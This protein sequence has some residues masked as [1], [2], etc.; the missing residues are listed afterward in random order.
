MHV[1]STRKL[2]LA[3]YTLLPLALCACVSGATLS[4]RVD[5]LALHT[6]R[7]HDAA[8]R[9]EAEREIALAEAHLEFLRYE[10]QRGKVVPARRHSEIALSSID[11]VRAM[12]DHRPECF[13]IV[14]ITDADADGV[15]DVDDNC[16]YTPNPQQIDI[17]DDGQGD[18]CDDDMDGDGV[19]NDA[20]NCPRTPNPDQRDSN[21][22][23]RG[24]LCS[25]DRDGDGITN[26][27][28]RCPDVPEDD[29]AWEDTDGCPDLDNDQDG[30][31]DDVD[32]CPNRAEDIDGWED[33][34]GCPDVDNDGDGVFDSVDQCPL[35]PEDLDNDRDADGCPEEDSLVRVTAEQLEI[36]Q[37]VNFA[38]NSATIVG[39]LSFAILDEVA[40]VL[41]D[42]TEMEVRIEGHTDSQGAASYNLTL[43]Q[44]RADA[45][46]AYLIERGIEAD[47]LRAVGFG[48][49]S[50]IDDN[51]TESGRATNRRVEFHI[52]NP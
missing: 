5:Y 17:D 29:D 25:D 24:D 30:L 13:G 35:D 40:Q 8:M 33:T 48:E 6:E 28:D 2:R 22:D 19:M 51:S 12:V 42:A 7:T 45:V 27:A 26:A 46:R 1:N 9:C 16:P 10:M 20:D 14:I 49:E 11:A 32:A 39:D 38:T 36:T 44:D 3:L 4:E 37:Q 52:L 15:E 41:Y 34:D 47:R 21:G 18:E 50:P 23:G 31:D 43:S